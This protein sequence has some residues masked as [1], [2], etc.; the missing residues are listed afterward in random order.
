[1]I[2]CHSQYMVRQRL[3]DELE[4]WWRRCLT[5]QHDRCGLRSQILDSARTSCKRIGFEKTRIADICRELGIS[6]RSFQ[7]HFQSQD[8]VLEVLWAR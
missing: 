6:R 5:Q 3:S 7:Q 2:Y 1:M 4:E 8:E